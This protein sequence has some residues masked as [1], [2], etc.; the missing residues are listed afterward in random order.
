[1]GAT[2][3]L[4]F[5]ENIIKNTEQELKELEDGKINN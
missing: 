3:N 4:D 2:D 1:M 5:C